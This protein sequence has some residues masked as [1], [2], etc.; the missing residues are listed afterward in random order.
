MKGAILSR[1]GHM[2]VE[3]IRFYNFPPQ[4]TVWESCSKC[5]NLLLYTNI[6]AVYKASQISYN[7]IQGKYYHMKGME[8]E[9]FY[10]LDGTLITKDNFNGR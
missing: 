1:T 4:S 5:D 2:T 8:R 10:D 3:N 9:I 6:G 7:G